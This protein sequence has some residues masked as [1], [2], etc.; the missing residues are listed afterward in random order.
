[1]ELGQGSDQRETGTGRSRGHWAWLIGVLYGLFVLGQATLSYVQAWTEAHREPM[2]ADAK[3]LRGTPPKEHSALIR[4]QAERGVD[5][6]LYLTDSSAP[7]NA[8]DKEAH[9]RDYILLQVGDAWV[10]VAVDPGVRKTD[11]VGRWAPFDSE[12]EGKFAG[13]LDSS[14]KELGVPAGA[15]IR[16]GLLRATK[17]DRQSRTVSSLVVGLLGLLFGL[18]CAW[19]WWVPSKPLVPDLSPQR[20]LNGRVIGCRRCGSDEPLFHA[21]FQQN[22]GMLVMHRYTTYEGNFCRPCVNKV[23]LHTL[24]VNL[25]L[26]WWG[27]KSFFYTLYFLF[28]NFIQRLSLRPVEPAGP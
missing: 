6:G 1:M 27:L 20:L 28:K 16:Q 17:D 25:F 4:I 8:P 3:F 9:K 2:V 14:A 11:L 19:R 13:L 15:W 23:F 18:Y 21:K 5:T 12:K 7:E 26:G 24:G 10:V 22:V